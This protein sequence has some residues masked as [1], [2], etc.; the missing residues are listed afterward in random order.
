MF[1]YFVRG[2]F[3]IFFRDDAM[4]RILIP[5]GLYFRFIYDVT[6]ISVIFSE[7]YNL[8]ADLSRFILGCSLSST[9]ID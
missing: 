2:I 7:L 1:K 8:R 5:I 6:L 3:L 4:Y 9:V